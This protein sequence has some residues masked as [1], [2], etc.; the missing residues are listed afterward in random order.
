MNVGILGQYDFDNFTLLNALMSEREQINTAIHEYTHFSLSNQSVYGTISYCLNKLIIPQDC[1]TDSDKKDVAMKFF[2]SNVLKVQEGMAVFIESIYFLLRDKKEYESFIND[3]YLNNRTYYDYVKPLCF[4]LNIIK[5]QK[6]EIVLAVSHAVFQ[7]A[8]ESM[9]ASIF[10]L[11]GKSFGTN[12]LIKRMVSTQDFSKEYIPNKRFFTMIDDCKKATSCDELIEMLWN[13]VEHKETINTVTEATKRFEKI[14]D[15]VLDIFSDSKYIDLYRNKL[16]K[17]EIS[18]KDV[19]EIFLQQIPTAFNEEYIAKKMKKASWEMIKQK[20]KN[21]EYSV[22]FLVGSVKENLSDLLIK[23]GVIEPKKSEDERE[24]LFFYDLISKEVYGCLLEEIQ[25][26]EILADGENKSVLLTS[27][28]NYDYEQDCIPKYSK[29]NRFTYIY[30]DRTYN[31]VI[32]YLNKWADK[33]VYYRYMVYES[34]PVLLIKNSNSSIFILPMTPIVA[35]EADR[36][37]RKNHR[38]MLMITD[39]ED[40]EYDSHVITDSK[41]R[42]EIDTIINCLFFINM[43]VP[44]DN[45]P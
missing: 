8:L 36:D 43:P 28:K 16:E 29:I 6:R 11:D 33:E 21:A 32:D 7:V 27:Y 38:N 37:I 10:D 4:I 5:G 30:C 20:C 19:S 9:N 22:L 31:N 12:K 45:N 13:K 23:M 44:N 3:L 39:A 40:G 17:I 15:F 24:I 2:L 14:K 1:K 35:D 34:M 41:K 25:L 42:D 18:E 26:Q